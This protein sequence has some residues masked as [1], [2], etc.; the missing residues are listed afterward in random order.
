MKCIEDYSASCL[1]S[2]DPSLFKK[3]IDGVIKFFEKF[4]TDKDFQRDY[5][6]YKSCFANE[7]DDWIA[8][9]AD[10]EKAL[11]EDLNDERNSTNKLLQ[12]C[13]DYLVFDHCMNT[14]APY[15]SLM[16]SSKFVC[17][18]VK[19]LSTEDYV[20]N[21]PQLE[22]TCAGAPNTYLAWSSILPLALMLLMRYACYHNRWLFS[23]Y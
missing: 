13:C 2:R 17:N 21:C 12:F 20:R 19:M 14:G 15:T 22:D 5:M 8:C 23:G 7:K 3:D 10:V 6:R 18:V 11:I 16:N 9:T 4:C 1:Q